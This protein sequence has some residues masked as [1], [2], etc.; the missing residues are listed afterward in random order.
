M[1]RLIVLRQAEP[2]MWERVGVV[3]VQGDDLSVEQAQTLAVE[4]AAKE[5]GAFIAIPFDYWS[6][7]EAEAQITVRP[8]RRGAPTVERDGGVE[9]EEGE[10]GH[11]FVD[12]DLEGLTQGPKS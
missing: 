8:V 12:P 5:G 7:Y 4:E 9:V 1:P 10:H 3:D 6:V 2:D 11:G